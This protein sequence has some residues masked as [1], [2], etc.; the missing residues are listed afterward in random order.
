LP[1]CDEV[2]VSVLKAFG[3][4]REDVRRGPARALRMDE[5]GRARR[6]AERR[7]TIVSDVNEATSLAAP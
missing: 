6:D 7:N 4:R 3:C 5:A 2:A 1:C